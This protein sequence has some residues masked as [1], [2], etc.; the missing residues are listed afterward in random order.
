[1]GWRRCRCSVDETKDGSLRQVDG[2]AVRDIGGMSPESAERSGFF[3]NGCDGVTYGCTDMMGTEDVP[4]SRRLVMSLRASATFRGTKKTPQGNT[5]RPLCR[6]GERRLA[7]TGSFAFHVLRPS[8]EN[9]ESLS[10][11]E[12]L[13]F[14]QAVYELGSAAWPEVSKLMARHPMVSK[15]KSFFNFAHCT[16]IYRDLMSAAGYDP[17]VDPIT[18]CRSANFPEQSL[19]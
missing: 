2:V 16:D 5:K 12:R 4:L 3:F 13:L 8:G 18:K 11:R 14:A 15:P 17:C 1:M 9:M 10:S 19:V 7:P 6:L